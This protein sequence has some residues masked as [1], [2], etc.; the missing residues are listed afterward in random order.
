MSFQDEMRTTYHMSHSPAALEA[1][2]VPGGHDY[3]A[4]GQYLDVLKGQIR[5]QL[6]RNPPNC[7]TAAGTAILAGFQAPKGYEQ[8]SDFL[9]LDGISSTSP[10]RQSLTVYLTKKG[11]VFLRDLLELADREGICLSYTLDYQGRQYPLPVEDRSLQK[12]HLL[13]H[14]NRL[15]ETRPKLR[16]HYTFRV[17]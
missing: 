1:R 9:L 4:A 17:A 7:F 10:F 14:T 11:Y 15:T 2:Q 5:N 12:R 8:T 16:V 6:R 13:P 3:Q